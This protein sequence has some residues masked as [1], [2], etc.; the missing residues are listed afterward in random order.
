MSRDGFNKNLE[1]K[2]TPKIGVLE[3]AIIT[4][5]YFLENLRTKM[6]FSEMIFTN[7]YNLKTIR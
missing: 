4:P 7:K 2:K 6:P 3:L 5:N 1:Q